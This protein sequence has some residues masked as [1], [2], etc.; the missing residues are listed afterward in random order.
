MDWHSRFLQQ[1]AWTRDLRVYLFER[2][3]LTLARRVLEVGCGSGAIL[4]DLATPATVHGLDLEP[5]RLAEARVHVPAAALVCGNALQL[6]YPPKVFE[7]TF[8]HFLLLWVRDPLLALLEMKRVTGTGGAVLA[9]AEPDYDSRVDKPEALAPLGRWQAESLQ[10]QGA[11]PGLGSR[12]ADLFRQADIPPIETGTLRSS[13]GSSIS[14]RIPY[15]T[16]RGS[17]GSSEAVPISAYHPESRSG[18]DLRFKGGESLPAPAGRDLEW[19][20]LEAD[21]AGWI[22]AQEILRMKAMDEQAWK[23]GTRVLHV[24]TYFAWGRV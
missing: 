3:G 19:A 7:I 16:G 23:L 12:L 10:R 6:P 8:C 1:A 9:L 11:D 14:S 22:P 24:P 18:R 20:V 4:S 15:G 21:L 17:H 5:L 13:P 2:A